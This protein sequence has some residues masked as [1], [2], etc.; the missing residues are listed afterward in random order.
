MAMFSTLV[1]VQYVLVG[2]RISFDLLNYIPAAGCVYHSRAVE[3][4]TVDN[5]SH[6][7]L[8]DGPSETLNTIGAFLEVG[9]SVLLPLFFK[10]TRL[11]F[12]RKCDNYLTGFILYFPLPD[13]QHSAMTLR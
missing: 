7:V 2:L 12:S 13:T 3:N 10:S 5:S 4:C 1:I 11:R 8:D 6:N 9:N